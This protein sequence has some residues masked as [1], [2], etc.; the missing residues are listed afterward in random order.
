M[1]LDLKKPLFVVV[2]TWN[3]AIFTNGW[4]ARYLFC[5]PEGERIDANELVEFGPAQRRIVYIRNIG[6]AAHAKRIEF[7]ANSMDP[8]TL[9]EIV[10]LVKRTITTLPHT[11]LGGVGVNFFFQVD[12][13]DASIIDALKT[14]DRIEQHYRVLMQSFES[15][16]AIA[17]REDVVLNLTRIPSP[18]NVLFDF[19]YHL[20]RISADSVNQL[21]GLVDQFLQHATNVLQT[22]YGL[23]G[24]ETRSHD[25]ARPQVVVQGE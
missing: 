1:F 22:V 5:V 23:D 7:F 14:R 19:N 25:F 10:E 21:D 20:S 13:P 9:N 17:D 2:G 4:I 16:I 18:D 3:P 11:P 24:Y 6:V 15:K 8:Q 12:D